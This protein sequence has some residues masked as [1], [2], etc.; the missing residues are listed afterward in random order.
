[1]KRDVKRIIPNR[2]YHDKIPY[3]RHA[4]IREDDIF[5][6][7]EGRIDWLF[8]LLCDGVI[9]LAVVAVAGDDIHYFGRIDR[10]FDFEKLCEGAISLAVVAVAGD[11]THYFDAA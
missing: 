3:L 11:D 5:D 2:N 10:P 8:E 9:R 6:A 7:L 1:M 4:V